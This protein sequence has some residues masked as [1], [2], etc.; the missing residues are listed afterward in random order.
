MSREQKELGPGR[1]K[2][3]LSHLRRASLVSGPLLELD[4][5]GG[6][7]GNGGLPSACSVSAPLPWRSPLNGGRE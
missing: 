4:R 3:V 5:D 6:R 7:G 2:H 1:P